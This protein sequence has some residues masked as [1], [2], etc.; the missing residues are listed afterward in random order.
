AKQQ[1]WRGGVLN[2]ICYKNKNSSDSFLDVIGQVHV[3]LLLP[4]NNSIYN[5]T[6]NVTVRYNVTSECQAQEG[7][8]NTSITNATFIHNQTLTSYLC[9]PTNNESNGFYNCTFGTSNKAQGNYSIM[10]NAS[11]P[12]YNSNA[13]LFV[14][15]FYLKNVLTAVQNQSVNRKAGG[16]GLVYQFN[17]SVYDPEGESVTC[18][19]FVNTSGLF[20]FQGSS[21]V[22]SGTGNCT[23]SVGN[24]TCAD[25]R[26]NSQY[27]FQ[28]VNGEPTNTFNT[29]VNADLNLTADNLTIDFISGPNSYVNRSNGN[30]TTLVMRLFDTD[31]QSYD[32]L[33]N[34]TFWI[35][36]NGSEYDSGNQTQS[37]SSG[38]S[39][40]DF[41]P[42]CSY[43][44]GVQGW[45]V[46]STDNCYLPINTTASSL[47]A[48]GNLIL[49]ISRPFGVEIIRGQNITLN[50]TI[51][52]DCQVPITDG[53][54]NFSANHNN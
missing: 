49:N 14:N 40:L 43:N 48:I 25:L 41:N 27:F 2:D 46:G 32:P 28:I 37:N 31:N 53:I 52:S 4:A 51:I 5:V 36:T 50:G 6:N 9:S 20:A 3:S 35:T 15:R 24:F 18:N 7:L 54:V 21:T 39:K 8:L 38:H 34:T 17:V 26:N 13:T 45:K 33:V 22:A 42:S 23:V 1:V 29:S 47:T 16:W 44:V 19:L 11:M 10:L 12:Y 30:F